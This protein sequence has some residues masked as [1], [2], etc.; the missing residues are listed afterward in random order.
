MSPEVVSTKNKNQPI[1][2]R[3]RPGEP[4]E[5][6]RAA[7]TNATAAASENILLEYGWDARQNLIK[8]IGIP[9]DIAKEIV[10]AA[11]DG[12]PDV[13]VEFDTVFL[14]KGRI[15]EPRKFVNFK[16]LQR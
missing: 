10:K 4:I 5:A 8:K 14:E 15:G 11:L 9:E 1:D 6:I 3:L 13:G 2:W 7:V 16:R 12:I